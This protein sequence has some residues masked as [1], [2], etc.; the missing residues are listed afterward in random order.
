MPPLSRHRRTVSEANINKNVNWLG[1][2]GVWTWYVSLLLLMW[3]TASALL[4]LAP[5]G[6]NNSGGGANGGGGG[7]GQSRY[8]WTVV[9]WLHGAASYWLLHWT[10]GSPCAED[11]GRFDQLTFWEQMDNET[12]G[13]STRKFFTLVPV[14]TLALAAHGGGLLSAALAGPGGGA[15]SGGGGAGGAGG[16]GGGL[17]GGEGGLGG[18]AG[19]GVGAG[20]GGGGGAAA[21]VETAR[22][23]MALNVAVA[24][25]LL[26][27]KLPAMHRVRIFGIGRW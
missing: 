12:Y 15:G 27:A 3:A 23:L 8:A 5:G 14:V 10:K 22:L 20:G 17:G 1:S 26:V 6:A 19:A 9:H 13:T 18:A 4:S 2:R 11:Q 21:A 7:A 16:G 25:L 24:A